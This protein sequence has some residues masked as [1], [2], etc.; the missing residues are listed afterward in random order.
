MGAVLWDM[1]GTL[2]DSADYHWRAWKDTMEA[3]GV[4]ITHDQFLATFGQRNDTILTQWLACD[5]ADARIGPIGDA[6][7]QCYRRLVRALGIS[8]LPGAAEW[9]QKL[10]G[11]GWAQAVASAAPRRNV[12]VVMEKLGLARYFQATTS[13]EDV[14][15]GKPD[16]EV[17]LIAAAKLGVPPGQCVVVEDAPAGIEAAKRAGMRSIGV[18]QGTRLDADIAVESLTELAPDAFEQLLGIGSGPR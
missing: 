18:R 2:V 4:A 3:Q 9:V 7:E 11:Q 17:F 13:A 5:R 15:H 1:D 6:K 16:P 12:E 14:H 10:Y 8:A